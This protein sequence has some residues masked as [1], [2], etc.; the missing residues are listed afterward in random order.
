MKFF[1]DLF[2]GVSNQS[3]ELARVLSAWTVLSTSALA[4]W[5]VYSGQDVSLNDYATAMMLVM[6]GC[7]VFIGAKDTA[8]AHAI[9]TEGAAK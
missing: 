2:T 7:A 3:F 9:K 4:G 1:R 6:G 5:K 8:R